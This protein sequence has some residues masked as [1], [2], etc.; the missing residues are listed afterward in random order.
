MG[1]SESFGLRTRSGPAVRLRLVFQ[2][3]AAALFAIL[4][5]I[6]TI[7]SPT[8]SRAQTIAIPGG[9]PVA[10]ASS[11][12]SAASN[13]PLKL[14]VSFKLRNRD[15]LNKLLAEQQDPKSPHYHHWLTPAQFNARFGR[16]PAE[17]R[18]A[19]EW[20]TSQHF[21]VLRSTNRGIDSTATVADA[22]E[23]FATSIAASADGAKYSNLSEP[24]IPARFADVIGL[25]EGLD[26]L[27][28]WM[29]IVG[30][31]VKRVPASHQS[32]ETAG[33]AAL[34]RRGGGA[35]PA[36]IVSSAVGSPA[37]QSFGFG[38]ADLWTFYD[39]TP[40]INGATDG[41]G[42]DCL[43]VV[44]DS[45]YHASSVTLFDTTFSLPTANITN[46]YPDGNQSPGVGNDEAEALV[47]SRMGPRRRAGGPATCLHRGPELQ[48]RRRS[49]D[50]FYPPGGERQC[51]RRDQLQ[52]RVLRSG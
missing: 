16:T 40:P 19:R 37:Y 26:N 36:A 52:L 28:H 23:T 3:A 24:Q 47:D 39:Q 12:S 50:G 2:P 1:F 20:L 21:R 44:E 35:A 42:G 27:R 11:T 10:A 9:R 17:V 14:H 41:G 33:K 32:A 8:G 31:P 49:L 7:F 38:P 48:Y 46:V 43:A 29:P 5:I 45:D 15:A 6:A 22:Q 34:P 51:L 13:L 30:R 18:A 25:I 4:L